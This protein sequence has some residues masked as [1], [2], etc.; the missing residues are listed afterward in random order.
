M[1]VLMTQLHCYVP[2]EVAQQAQRRA[3]QSGLSLSRYLADLV[4][5]DALASAPWP[6]GYF[7]LFGKWGGAPLERVPQLP[8]EERLQFK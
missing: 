1:E 4:K 7:K 5:R 3:A 2:E 8:Q 6:E